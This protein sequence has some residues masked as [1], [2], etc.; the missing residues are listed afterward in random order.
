MR[1]PDRA[2]IRDSAHPRLTSGTSSP[3]TPPP[4]NPE[5]SCSTPSRNRPGRRTVSGLFCAFN[6]GQTRVTA[7]CRRSEREPA[8]HGS[9]RS[10]RRPCGTVPIKNVAHQTPVTAPPPP[11]PAP[12]PANALPASSA[13]P[14]VPVPPVPPVPP[15]PASAQA[16]PIALHAAARAGHA[17]DPVRA[18]AGAHAGASHPAE[19]HLGRDLACGDRRTRRGDRG[20]S[21]VGLQPGR[22]LPQLRTRAQSR[23]HPGNHPAGGV[24]GRLGAAAHP[25]RPAHGAPAQVARFFRARHAGRERRWTAR[26]IRSPR[27]VDERGSSH[28][29]NRSAAAIGPVSRV[30]RERG[31]MPRS[32]R[33]RP[34]HASV[35]RNGVT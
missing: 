9:G 17:A 16:P 14:P 3:P 2:R 22:G 1:A 29:G 35:N 33:P 25:P 24:C 20:G 32:Q 8:R 23:L 6:A 19:W 26:P 5:R 11:A 30:G 7:Q 13:P 4:A 27:A 28:R 15:A 31:T 34:A 12:A 10:V 18:P 21:R